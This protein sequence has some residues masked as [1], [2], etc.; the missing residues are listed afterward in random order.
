MSALR[1]VTASK[2]DVLKFL[3]KESRSV[4]RHTK[5]FGPLPE[6][7]SASSS[8]SLSTVDGI[9]ATSEGSNAT[10][11]LQLPNPFLPR[12]NP[13]T[14]R[15]ADPKFSLRRQAD[16]VKKAKAAGMLHLMPPGPKTP[17]LDH[18]NSVVQKFNPHFAQAAAEA[19]EKQAEAAAEGKVWRKTPV[20]PSWIAHAQD[21]GAIEVG[22]KLQKLEDKVVQPIHWEGKVDLHMKPGADLG[23]KL[24]AG[25][26][27]MFKGH[28]F[29]RLRPKVEAK[30]EKALAFMDQRIEAYKNYYKKRRPNPLKPP[31]A[32]TKAAKLPF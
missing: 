9:A 5:F 21:A 32:T 2:A 8:S 22:Q 29:E 16:L 11:L 3:A 30:R 1:S 4:S 15:W 10:Q 26:K 27:K 7:T 23:I 25:K 24:Y 13:K 20:L 28:M 19:F 6:L 17:M 14:K 18:S 31:K 12:L